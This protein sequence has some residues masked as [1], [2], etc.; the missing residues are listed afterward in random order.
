MIVQL[1]AEVALLDRVIARINPVNPC[2]R[3]AFNLARENRDRKRRL[4]ETL[5]AKRLELNQARKRHAVRAK[6][7]SL[8]AVAQ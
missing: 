8:H 1:E 4:E 5:R 2:G 6:E 3:A 7:D